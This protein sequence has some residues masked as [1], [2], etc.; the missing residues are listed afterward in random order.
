MKKQLFYAEKLILAVIDNSRHKWPG[1]TE[2]SRQFSF[3][4]PV[5]EGFLLKDRKMKCS[6]MCF[7]LFLCGKDKIRRLNK[8]YRTID[9]PTDVLAFPLHEDF[10]GSLPPQ[11]NLGD[12]FICR[13]IAFKQARQFGREVHKEYI[14]LLIH[15]FLHL[16][17]MDHVTK[18]EAKDMAKWEQT[19]KKRLG[20]R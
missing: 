1:Q 18:K 8:E 17:G 13:P 9:L 12:V 19:L 11:L 6:R 4:I 10:Q 15:G 14:H 20:G 7:S 2:L 5:L 16:C 3:L